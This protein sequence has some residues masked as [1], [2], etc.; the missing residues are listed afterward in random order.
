VSSK[1]L[2]FALLA[3]LAAL[4]AVPIAS[5]ALG[6]RSA[7]AD[8]GTK[9]AKSD[10]RPI[11][12]DVKKTAL[13]ENALEGKLHG[14]A[15]GKVGEV[16][17]G[18]YVQLVREG[19][20]QVWT[21]LGEFA[22]LKHNELPKPD[23][24]VDNSTFWAPDF[25]RDFF[26]KLLYSQTPG[27]NSMANY[28]LEQSSGRYTVAG[29]TDG[30]VSVPGDMADYDD[31]PDANV[32]NFLVDSCNAWYDSQ[33]A[34]GKTAAQIDEYLSQ[35]DVSDRYDYDA[36]GDFNEPDGYIDTFQAV[37][38]GMGE[39]GGGPPTAIW[40][41]SWYAY[42]NLIGV[43]GPDF[44]MLG[45]L[46]IG[47]SAY[48]VG[49][50]TIQPEDGGLGVFAHEYGHDMGLPDL[51]DYYGEN[52]TGFWTLMSS[53][54]WLDEGKD[55][56]GNKPG[57]MG[58]WEKFQLGWAKY[59]VARAGQ[60]SSHKL[61]PMEYTTKQA[62]GVF[63]VL[64]K[65]S[66]TSSIGAPYA[67]ASYYYSGTG[68]DQDSRMY[69]AVDLP[70]GSSLSAKVMYDIELDWDYAYVVVSTDGGTTWEPVATSLSTSTDPNGQNFGNGI[71]GSSGGAWVDLTAD[72]SAYTGSVMLGFRYWTDGAYSE[73]G[74][75]IDDV[76]VTGLPLDGA[77]TDAGWTFAPSAGGFRV[78]N[79][80]ET[81]LFS[82][83]YVAEYRTYK[84]YDR[85]LKVGPYFFGYANDSTKYNWV[86]HFAYQD[87]LLIN[88]WDTSQADNNT[89]LH[90]GQGLLLP[91]DA[92]PKTLYR[93][94]GPRWRNR[95]QTYDSTFT[96]DRTDGIPNIHVNGVLSP[97]PSLAAVPVF[98]DTKSWYDPTNPL[99]SVMT[100]NTNTKITIAS[101]SAIDGFMQIQVAPVK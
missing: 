38:A 81:A 44:N 60:K 76:A 45:G 66:V 16:A 88:Y 92:H 48:W 34:A 68:D 33:I 14:K 18:Q 59:E 83:Y 53:G 70:A 89:G 11:S 17:R 74:L 9:G 86:D 62:Q 27:D 22:D 84:G 72:L 52:G 63:V 87:G 41:H 8:K 93:V 37:H 13:L 67:G 2:R 24:A 7:T 65:K 10:N 35:F 26:N 43:A 3:L 51:Y 5:A 19:T 98:N 21:L 97:V 95:I 32:W 58:V 47:D 78:T 25:S 28:Y 56:I 71:T 90:P 91:V 20:G 79:G 46:R 85:G 40:S 31:N 49:K 50:Y 94:D 77:E 54:S 12:L 29:N 100:P 36:D 4:V 73:T 75:R 101:I 57:H 6:A 1:L 39:E 82:H 23:R 69:K 15:Y 80:T 96:L 55:T 30:W 99:G 61:G 64:P 42:S